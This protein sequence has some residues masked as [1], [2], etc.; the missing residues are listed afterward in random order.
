VFRKEWVVQIKEMLNNDDEKSLPKVCN[1]LR[2]ATLL[3]NEKPEAYIPQCLSLGPL[4]HWKLEKKY[5]AS[6][7]VGG[8]ISSTEAYKGKSAAK[9]SNKLR[10]RGKGERSRRYCNA[11][12]LKEKPPSP[13]RGFTAISQR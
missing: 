6:C 7:S 3:L 13:P 5:I 2:V 10:N 9:F 8:R 11:D 12:L 1:I 4:H